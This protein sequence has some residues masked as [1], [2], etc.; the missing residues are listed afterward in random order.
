[1]RVVDLFSGCGGMS[2]GFCNEGFD[3]VAAFDNWDKVKVVYE[4]NFTHPFYLQDLSRVEDYIDL[5]ENLT[6]DII[7]GGPPC[8]DFSPAGLRDESRG[9]AGMTSVYADIIDRILPEW[10]VMENV[11]NLQK[12]TVWPQ[13]KESFKQS[14]YGLTV[15]VLNAAHCGVPQA[16]KRVFVIGH[17][18]GSDGELDTIIDA[19][20]SDKPMTMRDYFGDTWGIDHYFRMP[21]SYSRRGVF[22]MDEPSPTIR[23]V[24]RPIPPGY[25]RHPIDTEDP[26]KVRALTPLERAQIQTFPPEFEFTGSNTAINQM[27]GNAVPV[28]LAGFVARAIKTAVQ[29]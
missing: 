15:R 6:P 19:Q 5:V 18:N 4:K 14:G 20:L 7:I 24:H 23:G 16:R 3:V 10:F 21:T 9:R 25:K 2:L 13:V 17:L 29:I 1:M 8:Q 11:P 26:S 28:N 12:S 27:I 22:S